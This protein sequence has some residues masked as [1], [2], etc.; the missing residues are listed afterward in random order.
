MLL[1]IGALLRENFVFTILYF[2]IGAY[3]IGKWWSRSALEGVQIEREMQSRVFLGEEIKVGLVVKNP[4]W[5]PVLWIRLHEAL[6]VELSVPNFYQ[7]V[8]S[9]SSREKLTLSYHLQARK[10]GY[11]PIGPLTLYS[12]DI[13]GMGDQINKI[14]NEDYI[15]VF[16]K[17]I[18]LSKIQILSHSPMGSI[19]HSL[20]IYEDPSMVTGKRNYVAG[21]SL[22][23]IDWKS[24][25]S[26]GQ[27]QVKLFEPSI[28]LETALCLNLSAED[29]ALKTRY[30]ATELAIVV[31]A[32]IAN[33][34]ADKKQAVGLFTNGFDP[35]INSGVIHPILPRKGRSHVMRMLEVLAR[36]EVVEGRPIETQL[37]EVIH[38]LPWGTTIILITG[39]IDD[40]VFDQLFQ[41][42]RL[43][44]DVMLVFCGP[45]PDFQ[46]IKQKA[47]YFNFPVFQM[48]SEQDLNIWG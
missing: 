32:S 41:A 13:L 33:W 24:S 18:P 48:L 2:F 28:S 19:R 46:G 37:R 11:Y 14:Y 5:I 22:R 15:T 17:I 9:L 23:R 4:K 20:P 44:L 34:I 6:P 27:L 21:D 16:P 40:G 26:T 29:Y 8:I 45:I 25:A 42:R 1:V 39:R 30:P 31:A 38:H 47:E 7:R 12:G 3:A 35:Y 36:V 43:G 10:R